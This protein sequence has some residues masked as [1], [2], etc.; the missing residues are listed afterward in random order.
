V[1]CIQFFQGTPQTATCELACPP[2]FETREIG[3]Q[4]AKERRSAVLALPSALSPA[5]TN[6]LL[7]PEHPGFKRIRI[8]SPT[9]FEFD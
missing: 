3:D 1:I 9:D 6:F 2:S 5:D 8:A 4:W 7:N